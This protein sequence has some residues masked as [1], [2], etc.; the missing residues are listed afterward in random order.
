MHGPRAHVDVEDAAAIVGLV[1]ARGQVGRAARAEGVLLV[2]EPQRAGTARALEN[3]PQVPRQRGLEDLTDPCVRMVH[4]DAHAV[5]ECAVEAVLL[6]EVTVRRGMSVAVV[7]QHGMA[8]SGEVAPELMR[9]GLLGDHA[10]D[11]VS[12]RDRQAAVA[13][14]RRVD[15][16]SIAQVAGDGPFDG[17]TPRAATT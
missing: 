14:A 8:H 6:L 16:P 4:L 15:G 7:A 10:Q 3:C 1:G 11:A 13:G 9:P 12:G 17:V 5:H 2:E